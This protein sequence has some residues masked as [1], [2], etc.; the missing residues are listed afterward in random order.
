MMPF[1]SRFKLINGV[2][3]FMFDTS[4]EGLKKIISKGESQTVEF[5][6]RLPP[7][8]ILAKLLVAFANTNGGIILIGIGDNGEIIGM[9][10]KEVSVALKRLQQIGFTLFDSKIQTAMTHVNGRIIVFSIISKSPETLLPI[11]TSVG[12]VYKRIGVSTKKSIEKEI[13]ISLTTDEEI[14][15]FVAMSF[16]EE[17]EPA[18]VDYFKAMDRAI[19]ESK[20]PIKITKIDLLEGDYEISQQIIDEISKSDFILADLT[21]NPRNVYFEIGVARGCGKVVLQT[22]RSDTVLEFDIHNW[23]TIFYKNATELEKKLKPS[24]ENVYK[25]VLEMKGRASR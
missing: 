1:L 20:L 22:A 19:K 7:D 23:R 16:R 5:T 14:N 2:I 11:R 12:D 8:N 17:E 15:C 4:E 10:K 13:D 6:E 24:I 3:N 25:E 18:L 9:S 21:L